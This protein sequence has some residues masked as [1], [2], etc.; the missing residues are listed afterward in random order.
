V[1]PASA[2]ADDHSRHAGPGEEGGRDRA[3]AQAY[4]VGDSER[5]NT[6]AGMNH[7]MSWE[8]PEFVEIRMDAEISYMDDLD[9][10]DADLIED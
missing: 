4:S 2:L 1:P 10:D 3:L 7:M 6:P 5:A 8:T 9:R